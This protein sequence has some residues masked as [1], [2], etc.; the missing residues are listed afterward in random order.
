MHDGTERG[1]LVTLS[2]CPLP[3]EEQTRE[4]ETDPDDPSPRRPTN[5][6]RSAWCI[7]H[8][9]VVPEAEWDDHEVCEMREHHPNASRGAA[10]IGMG[11][12]TEKVTRYVSGIDGF[13]RCLGGGL[14]KG[15]R[16]L[17]T[18]AP[19]AGKSSLLLLILWCFAMQGMTV[20]YLTAEETRDEIEIR[21]RRMGFISTPR[22]ILHSTESWEDARAAIDRFRPRVIVLDS[23]QEMR[24]ANIDAD[25]GDDRQ[26]NQILK[27]TK[28]VVE[29]PRS[30]SM[31]I[32]GHIAKDGSAYGRMANVHKVTVWVHFSKDASG[33]RLLRTLKNRHGAEGEIAMFEHPPDGSAIREVADVSELL[34]RDA[35]G[36]VG[37]TAYPV[38]PSEKLARSLVLPVEASVSGVKGP[39]DRR[40]RVSQGVPEGMLEDALDRLT[41]CEVRFTDRSVRLQAPTVG[42]EVVA[43][44]GVMLA[45]C[46]ALVSS[47]ESWG[48]RVG[49]FGSLSAAGRVQPDP[50]VEQR[51]QALVRAS[52]PLVYGPPLGAFHAPEGLEYVPVEDLA[53]LVEHLKARA[54]FDRVQALRPSR[55]ATES[56]SPGAE[57]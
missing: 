44:G 9:R 18:G 30:P 5:G 19:G 17:F 29:G 27:N 20:L 15:T 49:V 16:V 11:G 35:L 42:E 48:A 4:P 54:A 32:I 57:G 8:E 52:V 40:L 25:A 28:A 38:M 10:P 31:L 47:S 56:D 36:R 23:L 13:D 51:L 22:L 6:T 41:D 24:C 45:V 7:D 2:A 3:R 1:L 46:A 39:N 34:L 53:A 43:D 21:F 14:V 37:V 33:K 26:V 50:Q 12:S 55:A